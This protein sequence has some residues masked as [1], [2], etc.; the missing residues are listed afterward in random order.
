[1][2]P[3][4]PVA[5][6]LRGRVLTNVVALPRAAVRELDRVILVHR[7]KRTLASRRIVPVWADEDHVV[8]DAGGLPPG[9]LLA[10]THLVY[11]PE[12]SAV[13]IIPEAGGGAEKPGPPA[14]GA[15]P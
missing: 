3:G 8:V 1:L 15:T 6:V 11:A 5:G 9:H 14:K 12:G 4:Q 2:R 7:E 10:T 13:E